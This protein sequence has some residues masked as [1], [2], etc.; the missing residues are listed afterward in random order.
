VE[1]PQQDR[2]EDQ[3]LIIALSGYADRFEIAVRRGDEVMAASVAVAIADSLRRFFPRELS[4]AS[5]TGINVSGRHAFLASPSSG[6]SQMDAEYQRLVEASMQE[7]KETLRADGVAKAIE[8]LAPTGILAEVNS[9][10]N[11]FQIMET[12]LATSPRS[13]RLDFLPQV[14]KLALWAGEVDKAKEYARE[15]LVLV[16]PGTAVGGGDEIHDGN[17]V[18][19]LIALQEGDTE[20]A[21]QHL[22]ESVRISGS[23]EMRM[24]GPNLSLASELLKRNE[25]DVVIRYLEECKRFWFVARAQLDTW[26]EM[27]RN[28]ERLEFDPI[29]LSH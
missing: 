27:L 29:Y 3:S 9:P 11:E 14:A 2:P 4:E 6:K 10:Q 17:M 13:L 28:G 23:M 25:I 15:I 5:A 12:K 8:K 22:L 16:P 20:R 19:G 7:F 21:K 26:I 1:H 18:L 24:T